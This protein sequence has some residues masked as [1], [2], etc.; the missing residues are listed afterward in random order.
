MFWSILIYQLRHKHP[1][2]VSEGEETESVC[3]SV[4]NKLRL[5]P[6]DIFFGEKKQEKTE[7]TTVGTVIRGL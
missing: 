7:I 3:T 6:F 1:Q 5:Q 4:W 2:R